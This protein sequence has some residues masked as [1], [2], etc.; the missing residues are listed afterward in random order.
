MGG[1]RGS[2]DKLSI[3]RAMKWKAAFLGGDLA[4][5]IR[6]YLNLVFGF[7]DSLSPLPSTAGASKTCFLLKERKLDDSVMFNVFAAVSK[8]CS[9][10]F[11][12]LSARGG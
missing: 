12:L 5:K 2:L 10:H 4:G 1:N 9:P 3:L 11:V 7:F 8:S 6:A